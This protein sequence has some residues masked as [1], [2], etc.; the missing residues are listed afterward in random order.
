[1]GTHQENFDMIGSIDEQYYNGYADFSVHQVMLSDVPRM[2]FY[3][4][5]L[6]ETNVRGKVVVDVGGGS[7]ILSFFAAKAGAQ[8][9]F[10]IEGSTLSTILP[11]IMNDN[12]LGGKISVLPNTVESIIDK[13]VAHFLTTYS[14]LKETNGIS[15]IVS[16]W[17]GFYLLHEG[18]LQSVLAARNFFSEVNKALGITT[19]IDMIPSSST[20]HAAPISLT[21]FKDKYVGKWKDCYGFN[22]ERL[23]KL[24]YEQL[25]DSSPLIETLPP[26]CLVHEGHTFWSADLTNLDP[27]DLDYIHATRDFSFCDSEI[28]KSHLTNNGK[29]SI[30]GFVL[31]FTVS[32]KSL[33]LDT[34]PSSRTTHWKQTITLL[35]HSY[36]K[37]ESVCFLSSNESLSLSLT[38]ELCDENRRFYSI[39][40][41]IN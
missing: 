4:S 32:Y 37:D 33:T 22:L 17:M 35:P 3:K 28:F 21:P 15:I 10:C 1:M 31:W 20:I 5:A 41:E 27:E 16:E 26:K 9:V 13:G 39:S 24:A 30:D 19:S 40:T 36:R 7:G 38:L 23:G 12:E 14:F 29:V 34:S 18:M 6:S 25:L 8:H 2:E 11:D